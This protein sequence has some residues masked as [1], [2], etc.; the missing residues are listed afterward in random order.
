MEDKGS[1]KHERSPS[2]GGAFARQHRNS[3]TSAIQIF[4]T[5]GVLVYS[6]IMLPLLTGVRAGQYL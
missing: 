2:T 1:T 6:L 4:A 5:T 3:I